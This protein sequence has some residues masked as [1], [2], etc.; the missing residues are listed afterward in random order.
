MITKLLKAPFTRLMATALL[1][2]SPP[3]IAQNM[4]YAPQKETQEQ[5]VSTQATQLKDVL[6]VLK[7]K[8][9]VDIMFELRS[10]DGL[11]VPAS[12]INMEQSL[13]RN[14][15]KVLTPFGLTFKKVNRQSYLVLDD[16]KRVK[17]APRGSNYPEESLNNLPG[18]TSQPVPGQQGGF[19]PPRSVE[20][21]ALTERQVTGKVTDE[22]GMG[23]PG[24][25]ILVKG[26]QTGT[27]T[28]SNGSYHLSV[29]DG[30]A[31]LVFSFVGYLSEEVPVGN[32]GSIELSLKVDEKSLE[33]VVVV[34]YGVV[35]KSD[36]TG[37]VASVTKE[38]LSAYPAASAVQA[39]QGRAAGVV[40][41][42]SN[43]EP[44]GD[45]KIRIRGGTSINASSDPLFVV[46]GLVGGVLPPP[47]DI[48]SIEVLKDAS[49]SA[50]YGSRGANGV[51]MITTK[52][53]KSG[54]PQINI[55]S[56]YSLQ[57]EIGRLDL[58]NARQFAEYINE[59]RNSSFYDV[60]NLEADTDWQDMIF[61]QGHIQNHQLSISGGNDKMK[62]YV[63]G[64]YFG[65]KG[66]IKTSAFNRYSL[67]TNFKFDVSKHI[68]LSLSSTLLNSQSDGVMTSSAGGASNAGVVMAAQRFDP[69]QGILDETGKYSQS[70]VGVAAFENPMAVIDGREEET[71]QDNVQVNA[72]AEFDLAKGLVF[73]STFGTIIRNSQNGVY[74]NRISNLGETTNGQGSLSHGRN[75][76][77]LTEQYLN[78]NFNAGMKSNFVL[79]GGFSYQ[80]F[81]NTNF[82]VTNT[83]FIT[84]ALGFW[85]LGVGTN[86]KAPGS[87]FTESAIMSYYGRL[88]Y[89]FDD[90]YLLTF[91]GRYDGASQFS[92]NNKWS[93]FPS[94]AF[95]WNVSNEKFY[96]QNPVF[97]SLKLRTSYGLTGNQGIGAYESLARISST[98]FVMN[99]SVVSSVRPTSIANKD[100]TWE[101]TTQFNVGI[102][103]DLFSNRI[104]ISGDYYY[105]L[106]KDLLCNVPIPAFSGYQSRLQNLGEIENK[107]VELQIN[108]RNLVNAFKWSTGLNLTFN[109]N[110]VLSL[111]GGVD[112]IFAS[113]PGFSGSIQNSILKEGESIGSFYG[114]VYQGVY[115]AGDEFIP[116]GAFEKEPGGEK[117]ADLNNDGVLDSKD[118]KIIGNPN[119]RAVW[120]LNNDFSYKGFSM[121]IFF[122]AFTGGDMLNLVKMEL[123]R[124]S[125]NSN[126][127]TDA[128]RRWTPQNTDTDVPKAAAGRSPLTS[129][130]FVEDGSFVRLKNISLG[131]DLSP[132]LLGRFK[133]RSARIYLSGQNL[134]TFTR[135]S[136]VDPEVAFRSGG[137]TNSNI[138][139]GLDFD[140]YPNT[141]S[142]TFGVNLGF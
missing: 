19:E 20:S 26:T 134:L 23:L 49:A 47:D 54:K 1:F 38:E 125:G 121:N 92:E 66:V 61:Q 14:L 120:G 110:K 15:D 71:K 86:F 85:N 52:S 124:L 28:D 62:Y 103:V 112:I 128:L 73:N 99:N 136:G 70:R 88:N 39:L 126:A 36:L 45:F 117:Y 93:F 131:Y 81:Q 69:D 50:I 108:S 105:K 46:D 21:A 44:G 31:V 77:F 67:N 87:E 63:S 72:K 115:Q 40:V 53:G 140:S 41:Q 55:N 142:W 58:L 29:P 25:S 17:P 8:Y 18:Q 12:V 118:R 56:S 104:N 139:L 6:N 30:D 33:E 11:T 90:R 127:T 5:R 60:N 16:K 94:G 35:K 122:Q 10:V 48:A 57:K 82:S 97:P 68:R 129:T 137:T 116:G 37:S 80:K 84:D 132:E 141:T 133:I 114:Y 79:T 135:Y 96:P 24:V 32:R 107:G 4:A 76:N 34:G 111:P 64:I 43:A 123:D 3:G 138:N 59:A 9:Q 113:V 74:N 83:G 78:Y 51:I 2:G 106:T 130:R 98:F 91:T 102:D 100:L 119:P 95:S 7:S 89:N 22:S 109:R 27:T 65:Q 101:K 42:S 13:E 75:Y